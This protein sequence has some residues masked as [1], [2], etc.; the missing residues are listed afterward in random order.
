MNWDPARLEVWIG[1][2]IDLTSVRL[3]SPNRCIE[4]HR[5]GRVLP[6]EVALIGSLLLIR[7]LLAVRACVSSDCISLVFVVLYISLLSLCKVENSV[8][9]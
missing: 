8:D 1:R 6:I 2:S 7:S 9:L 4:E 3:R 5:T